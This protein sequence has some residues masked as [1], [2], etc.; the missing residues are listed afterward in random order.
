MVSLRSQA[1]RAPLDTMAVFADLVASSDVSEEQRQ[2]Y[3]IRLRRESRRLSGLIDNALELKL[4][5]AGRRDLDLGPVDVGAII[6]RAVLAAGDEQGLPIEIRAPEHLPLVW[7]DAEAILEVLA[8][9]L[10]NARRFSPGGGAITIEAVEVGDMVEISIQD[11]GIGLEAEELPKIFRK[12][13]RA[14]NGVRMRGP[15]AGLGLAINRRIVESH[16]GQVVASSGG[17]GNGARF[18]FSLPVERDPKRS[19][20]VLIVDGDAAF[21]RLLKTELANVGVETLRAS[22]TETAKQLLMETSPRAIVLD[23]RLAGLLDGHR[24]DPV[25]R[26]PVVVLAAEDVPAAELSALESLGVVDVLPKEAGAPQAAAAL[27]AEVLTP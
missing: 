27:I 4:L 13:Y 1:L 15:G 9:F 12:F 20:Y 21:A 10:D 11:N 14:E 7:A 16:G 26:I 19:D 17:P 2:L 25:P 22:D 18:H 8:N 23:L 6:R 5:E 24:A 3:A